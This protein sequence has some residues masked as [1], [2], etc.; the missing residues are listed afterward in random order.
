MMKGHTVRAT[1]VKAA[2]Q[3]GNLEITY[4]NGKVVRYS[5][6]AVRNILN[7]AHLLVEQAQQPD[8]VSDEQWAL[9]AR[10]FV[11]GVTSAAL[12]GFG[13][14]AY[15]TAD[16]TFVSL[17]VREADEDWNTVYVY[18]MIAHLRKPEGCPVPIGSWSLHS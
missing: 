5:P 9:N 11:N 10:S 15:V 1:H 13:K 6:E 17:F 8:Y 16:D 2:D 12:T 4:D 3:Y 14:R 18:G 7:G